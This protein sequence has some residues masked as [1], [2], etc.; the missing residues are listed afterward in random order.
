MSGDVSDRKR[1]VSITKGNLRNNHIY[2]SG[3][4]DFFPTKCYGGPRKEKGMGKPVIL[5][6]E[7]LSG[8]VET[9]IA[10][11]GSNGV[12]RNF[13]RKRGWVRKFFQKH[14]IRV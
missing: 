5:I 10:T 3:H 14:E 8:K 11:N 7:G 13:F 9:D 4:H 2:L 6:V 12:P 1:L